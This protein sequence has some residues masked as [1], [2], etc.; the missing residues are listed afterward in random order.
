V[1]NEVLRGVGTALKT[2]FLKNGSYD[3]FKNTHFEMW[4]VSL[5]T[6]HTQFLC[7]VHFHKLPLKTHRGFMTNLNFIDREVVGSS[8]VRV[9]ENIQKC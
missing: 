1:K 5:K 7:R 8:L 4:K 2:G 3:F 9:M 6:P